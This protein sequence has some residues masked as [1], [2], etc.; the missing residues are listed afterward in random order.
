MDHHHDIPQLLEN[1]MDASGISE[2]WISVYELRMYFH[3][4]ESSAPAISGYLRRIYRNPCH[5][6]LYSV[7]KI[8][9]I[10]VTIPQRRT[11]KRYLVK[12][13]SPSRRKASDS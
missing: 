6:G 8:E 1:F 12:K 4:D 13:R 2:R 9:K 11:L 5:T 7:E 10:Q 3:L